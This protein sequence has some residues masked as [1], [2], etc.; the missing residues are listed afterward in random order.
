MPTGCKWKWASILK[1][2]RRKCTGQMDCLSPW[3][4]MIVMP[5]SWLTY[6]PC[7]W[8]PVCDHFVLAARQKDAAVG[9]VSELV[10]AVKQPRPLSESVNRPFFRKSSE[11]EQALDGGVG[12]RNSENVP[13]GRRNSQGSRRNSFQ[14][15]SEIPEEIKKKPRKSGLSSF[16]GYNFFQL[17]F[18]CVVKLSTICLCSTEIG[19]GITI[20][21]FKNGWT[22][23]FCSKSNSD[24]KLCKWW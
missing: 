23:F 3:S 24:V 16:I 5:F 10:I 12:R 6:S 21:M 18:V 4:D 15:L 19:Y 17:F 14:T 2:P 9:S 20:S 13:P 22:L 11:A 8:F 1:V 7:L